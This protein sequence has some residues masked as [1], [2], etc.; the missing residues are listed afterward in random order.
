MKAIIFA[1]GVGRRL[2][3][4]TQGKPKCLVE[5][6]GRTLLSRHVECLNRLGVSH[7]VL[8]VG[9]AQDAIREAMAASLPHV[10]FD[11]W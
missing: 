10:P 6:G 3:A 11:G 2:Q 8:V 5:I 1:A 9:F 4:V 7:I